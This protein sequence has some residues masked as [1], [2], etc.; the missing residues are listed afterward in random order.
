MPIDDSS[1][2]DAD[3]ASEDRIA[4]EDRSDD[5][6]EHAGCAAR[7]PDALALAGPSPAGRPASTTL[8]PQKNRKKARIIVSVDPGLL[9]RVTRAAQSQGLDR[10]AYLTLAAAYAIDNAVD[11]GALH[12]ARVAE[13]LRAQDED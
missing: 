4:T 1:H 5:A 12:R 11:L 8:K 6:T 9:T 3:D 10:S 2:P 7:E 13:A